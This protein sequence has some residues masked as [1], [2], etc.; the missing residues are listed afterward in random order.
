MFFRQQVNRMR[1]T[2][3]DRLDD[4]AFDA[5]PYAITGET[6]PKLGHY[7]DRFGLNLGGPLRI[8]HIYN[9]SDKTYFFANY[10]HDIQTSA[11]NTFS[12]V[13]TI[14]ERSG[15]FCGTSLY[16]PFSN[17]STPFPAIADPNC[18]G[19]LAQQLPINS[20][21]AGLLSYIPTPNLAASVQNFLLQTTLPENTDNLNVH[22]LHTLNSKWNLNG[23]YNFESVRGNTISNFPGIGGNQ[24]TR[25][26]SVDFGVSHNWSPR[27]VESTSINWSRSRLQ[28]LS[29]NSYGANIAANLGI[30]G[31]SGQPID[32]G[33]PQISLTNFSGI[34]DP[35]PSLVRNQTFRFDDGLTWVHAAHTMQFGG[36]IRRLQF[37]TDSSPNPRGQFVFTGL[38]TSEL[39]ASGAPV[40]GTGSDLA[41]FLLG[42]PFSTSEQFGNP[43]TYFRSWGFAAYAQ[44]DWRVNKVFTFEYG[45]R[46]DAV[47][48]PVEL[49]NNIVNL[50]MNPDIAT[51][52]ASGASCPGCVALVQSGGAG[53]FSGAFPRALIHGDYDNFAPRIGFAWEPK[54]IKPRT[55][56]RGGY[57]IFYNESGYDTLAR[58]LAYQ[59]PISTA[60]T[61]TS[62]A[63]EQLT[64]EN[65]FL[66]PQSSANFIANT[67]AV[68]PFY[69]NAYAQIWTMGTETSFSQNWILDLTYTG[70]KGTNL[71]VLR[72]PNRAPLGTSA[73]DIQAFRVDPDA[74]GFTYDQ[75]GA[76]SIYNA[77]QVRVM[78]R[79]THGLM[80]QGIYTYG[81]SLDDASSIGGGTGTVEQIDGDLAAERGLST[82]DIRH[83]MRVFSMYELPFGQRSRWANHGWTER[84]FGDWRLMNIFTWQTGMP[85]TALLGGTASDNGTGANFSLRAEQSGNPN[86][87]V[88]GGA[89]LSYFNTSVFGLPATDT[90]GNE[91]RG[92]IE[93]P[94]TLSWNMS[95]AKTFRFGPE[96]RHMLNVQWQ[97]QNLT[98]TPSFNGLGTVYGSSFFGQVTSASSMR[99][100]SLMARFNF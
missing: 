65:G 74:T 51:I 54:F 9:G 31:V 37:N 42:L 69:K 87:G 63:T 30:T 97:M 43:N 34:D 40:T 24:S 98:N 73:A 48:P 46:Y 45:V 89:P 8:P 99:T 76:N 26:Q 7:D 50:D 88:C 77:L 13:P 84:L 82:F 96:R 80:L 1:F 95:V 61:L 62:S 25:D 28:S 20:A 53:P 86:T 35:I 67:E 22:V 75:S 15:L 19:G 5:R 11:V 38:L 85:Y 72:A 56:V 68:D 3:Y 64:L 12:T 93:G 47:T 90:Y 57:S 91:R 83:Q 59:P 32:Y 41:D 71:D 49:F 6:S 81:K 33:I 92:A 100:M 94:C 16:E 17:P 70:T 39:D 10:Q 21:A 78:H 18:T 60:Q 29:D 23:G 52:A 66:P 27:L 55:V 4:S 14:E 58:E 44:D 36:E 79:F 2:F